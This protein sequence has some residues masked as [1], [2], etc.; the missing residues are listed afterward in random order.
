M[1][2]SI[3]FSIIALAVAAGAY[4]WWSATQ[5]PVDSGAVAEHMP[6]TWQSTTDTKFTREISAGV[7]VDRYV[8]DMG[9]GTGGSWSI[10]DPAKEE[11]LKSR[12]AALGGATVV[13]VV[14]GNGSDPIDTTYFS[15]NTVDETSMTTTD[16]SG[17]GEVTIWTRL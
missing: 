17:R 1:T 2:K 4:V 14:W 11:A 12:A 7:I 9:A 8:G 5:S 13:K 10:V 6:G 3:G 16:L 15:V